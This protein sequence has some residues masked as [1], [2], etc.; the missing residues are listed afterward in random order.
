MKIAV[1]SDSHDNTEK[2]KNFVKEVNRLNIETIIHCGDIISP[3]SA[4]LFKK[5]NSEFIAIFGN[6]DGETAGLLK[7]FHEIKKP[8]IEIELYG[9]SFAI[10]HEPILIEKITGKVDYILY[11]HTHSLEIKQ[12]NGTTIINPGEL[13]GYITE[14]STFVIL[15]PVTGETKI[16]EI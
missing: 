5:A 12:I 10:M 11:G 16:M 9:K 7:K 15:N 14:K 1:V 6:N 13:C 8:P 2:I 4:T 3:F